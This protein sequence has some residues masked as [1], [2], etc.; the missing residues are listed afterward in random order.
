MGVF[1]ASGPLGFRAQ[2]K[3]SKIIWGVSENRR[4]LEKYPK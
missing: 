3:G 1:Q 2:V 4:T